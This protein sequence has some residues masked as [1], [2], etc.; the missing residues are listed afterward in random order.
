MAGGR[1]ASTPLA[2]VAHGV[3]AGVAGTAVM[4]AAQMLWANSQP[5]P[6]PSGQADGDPWA[7]ASMPALVARKIGEGLFDTQVSAERIPVLTN[8]MHWGYGTSWGVVF[9]LAAPSVP[10]R[11]VRNGLLF[12]TAVMAMSYAQLVPMGIYRPPWTYPAKDIATELGFHL[13]Y[14]LG[15]AGGHRAIV[16]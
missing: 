9:G 5:A 4:T 16:R 12:G 8:A 1:A 7:G 13:A 10:A 15:V 2:A 6:E 3:A 11:P 14:G